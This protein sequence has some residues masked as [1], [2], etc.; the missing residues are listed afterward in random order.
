MG[1]G[2]SVGVA[3][4]GIARSVPALAFAA[5]ADVPGRQPCPRKGSEVIAS[6]KLVRV[7]VYPPTKE[8]YPP[9]RRTE[10]CLAGGGARMT[11]LGPEELHEFRR[12]SF[13]VVA[14]SGTAM[15]YAIGHFGT[16]SGG[17]RV[18]VADI[19]TRRILRELPGGGF[20]DAGFGGGT[21]RRDFVLDHSGSVAWIDEEIGPVSRRTKTFV[22]HR[23][24]VGGEE[25]V[26]DEGPDIAPRSLELR[27]GTLRWQ[28]AGTQRTA[29]LT[30]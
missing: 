13:E 23:A 5:R 24:P 6:D 7:Y 29:R 12:T 11:L 26:L 2:K 8:R 9:T 22:V 21:Y 25:V 27:A 20:A 14:L 19:A 3:L 15:A 16:D 28:D 30:P 1:S 17:Y 18:L 10:A 4:A